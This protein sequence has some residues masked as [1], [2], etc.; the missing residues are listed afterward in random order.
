MT[1][2]PG[3]WI[4]FLFFLFV[5]NERNHIAAMNVNKCIHTLYVFVYCIHSF[6]HFNYRQK[7]LHSLANNNNNNN[8]NLIFDNAIFE[9][10]NQF[11]IYI[12]TQG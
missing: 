4:L 12:S 8:N 10:F 5:E 9:S 7:K 2:R 3:N 11:T 1:I 6:I